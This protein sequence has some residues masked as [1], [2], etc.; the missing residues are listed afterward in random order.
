MSIRVRLPEDMVKNFTKDIIFTVTIDFYL[1]EAIDPREDE[2]EDMSY[3]VNYDL[4]IGYAN[5][6]LASPVDKRKT[7]LDTVEVQTAKAETS[8]VPTISGKGKRKKAEKAPSM[9][10]STRVT[11]SVQNKK[12][13]EPKVYAKKETASKKRSQK[14]IL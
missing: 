14:L 13:P 3:E 1:M 4:L 8:S 10:K 9:I 6:L 12:E 2:M 11:L 7:R 5:N